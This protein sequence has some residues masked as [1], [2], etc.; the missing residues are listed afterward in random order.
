MKMRNK[1]FGGFTLLELVIVIVIIGI[2]STIAMPLYFKAIERAR[3]AEA[4]TVLGMLRKSQIN[5]YS[6]K[7]NFITTG[8]FIEGSSAGGFLDVNISKPK[9]FNTKL[10]ASSPVGTNDSDIWLAMAQRNDYQAFPGFGQYIICISSAGV[11]S[12]TDVN[13]SACE[14]RLGLS[15]TPEC[16]Q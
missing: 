8:S 7:G 13:G 1:F 10:V 15:K 6:E 11:V 16:P 9:Y 5:Y 12:C 3:V 14:G 4:M 2:L